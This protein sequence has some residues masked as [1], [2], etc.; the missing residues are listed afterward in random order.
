MSSGAY[1]ILIGITFVSVSQTIVVSCQSTLVEHHEFVQ[2]SNPETDRSVMVV[3][4]GREVEQKRLL[5]HLSKRDVRPTVLI[6]QNMIV[7][8]CSSLRCRPAYCIGPG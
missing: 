2:V 1:L 6:K 7:T 3:D 4:M 8:G 5:V